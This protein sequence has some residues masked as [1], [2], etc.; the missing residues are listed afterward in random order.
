MGFSTSLASALLMITMLEIFIMFVGISID[1]VSELSER[2]YSANLIDSR[3]LMDRCS[4][5][6]VSISAIA[7]GVAIYVNVS[8]NGSMQWWDYRKVYLILD[9]L[10]INGSKI[11]YMASA[12]SLPYIVFGDAINPGI[13]DPGEILGIEYSLQ[14]AYI[15]N[16]SK[17][18]VIFSTQYG[19]VCVG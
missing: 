5:I 19:G 2:L 16:I 1:R 7:S 3:S 11:S 18:R 9:I 4:V 10:F 8:N 15:D 12:A 13:A 6:N 17:V 14:G